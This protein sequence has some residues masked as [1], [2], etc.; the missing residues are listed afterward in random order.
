[1]TADA[2]AAWAWVTVRNATSD[3]LVYGPVDVGSW[4]SGG[5][6]IHRVGEGHYQVTFYGAQEDGS[7]ASVALVSPM[8]SSA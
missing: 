1:M 8:G 6:G 3:S 7:G 5:A 2:G 4:N